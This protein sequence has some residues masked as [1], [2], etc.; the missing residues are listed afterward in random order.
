[1]FSEISDLEAVGLDPI[2]HPRLAELRFYD[3][4]LAPGEILFVPV[5]WWHQ[6]RSLDFSVTATFT[7]FRWRND[8]YLDY[9]SG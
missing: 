2:R 7:N 9:P 8:A 6:V 4:Q 5:G 1:M 3:V